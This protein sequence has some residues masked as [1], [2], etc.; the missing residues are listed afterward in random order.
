MWYKIDLEPDDND[1]LLVTVPDFPEI[2]TYGDDEAGAHANALGAIEEAIAARIA[3]GEDLPH[4]LAKVPGRGH[5]VRLPALTYLKEALY[6][7]CRKRKVNRAELGRRLGWHREQ[8]DRL[9]RLDHNSRLDQL[10]A[11]F[12]AI[13]VPLGFELR[14]PWAA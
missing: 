13:E 10:E 2:T 6:M 11:A 9:F 1:T 12:N 14:T 7:T 4:P 8:V 5:Y 3:D